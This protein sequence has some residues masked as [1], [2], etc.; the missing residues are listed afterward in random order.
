MDPV[1]A[2]FLAVKAFCE[3]V[4]EIEKGQPQA[5][6]DAA[7]ARWDRLVTTLD[8]IFPAPK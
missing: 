4:T 8:R 3:M 5:S 2:F 7:W 1:T 6:K